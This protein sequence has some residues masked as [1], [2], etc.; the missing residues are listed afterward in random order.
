M[1]IVVKTPFS[2]PSRSGTPCR[3]AGGAWL[4]PPPFL[5]SMSA[6]WQI[7]WV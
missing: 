2:T 1:E 5:W 7:P 3:R 4:P 6:R